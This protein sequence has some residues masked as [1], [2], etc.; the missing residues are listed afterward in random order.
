MVEN[1]SKIYKNIGYIV[2]ETDA[3]EPGILKKFEPF[4]KD[5]ITAFAGN[6]GVGK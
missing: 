2:I 6:S 5:Q 4:L 3:K 1:L